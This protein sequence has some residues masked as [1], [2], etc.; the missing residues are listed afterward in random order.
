MADA[1]TPMHHFQSTEYEV[2]DL[3]LASSATFDA[4]EVDLDAESY[5]NLSDTPPSAEIDI[6]LRLRGDFTL[7]RYQSIEYSI[8]HR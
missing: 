1:V 4:Y 2:L 5:R 7:I 8:E 6:R 3:P